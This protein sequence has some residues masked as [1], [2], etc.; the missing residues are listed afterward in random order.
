M[1]KNPRIPRFGCKYARNYAHTLI[2]NEMRVPLC[3]FQMCCHRVC[4]CSSG[5]LQFNSTAEVSGKN[6][7][8]P[9]AHNK[10]SSS[11]S[12]ESESSKK[13]EAKKRFCLCWQ[14]KKPF[15]PSKKSFSNKSVAKKT[16]C[17]IS[18]FCVI[19]LVLFW[20]FQSPESMRFP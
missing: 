7:S 3:T 11:N 4:D 1:E 10:N 16:L 13:I 20:F 6:A 17:D 2:S 12:S 18:C 8:M 14:K 5:Y 9:C 19:L 15:L